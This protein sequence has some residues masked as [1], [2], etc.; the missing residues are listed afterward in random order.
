[1]KKAK[2]VWITNPSKR[3]VILFSILWLIGIALLVISMTDLFTK[4]IFQRK[5]IMMYLLILGSTV[6]IFKL[7][8]NYFKYKA[9]H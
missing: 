9:F 2:N 7:F 1:M 4:S 6:T 8:R 3:Q 5:Y